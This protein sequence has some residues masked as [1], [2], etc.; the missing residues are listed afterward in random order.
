M[1][2]DID[3]RHL[4]AFARESARDPFPEPGAGPG[5]EGNLFG[6]THAYPLAWYSR[7]LQRALRRLSRFE[8]HGVEIGDELRLRVELH[9]LSRRTRKPEQPAV[10]AP[11]HIALVIGIDPVD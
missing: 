3:H 8:R 11:Q 10:P 5:D 4:C 1:P 9:T 2:I 7:P 6:E